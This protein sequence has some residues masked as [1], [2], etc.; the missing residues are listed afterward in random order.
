MYLHTEFYLQAYGDT[1]EEKLPTN[2]F[3]W[4]FHSLFYA[5]IRKSAQTQTT[6]LWR[7]ETH[8]EISCTVRNNGVVSIIK[9]TYLDE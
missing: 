1:V 2:L 6:P 8:M 9:L 3:S 5:Q 7:M 4:H